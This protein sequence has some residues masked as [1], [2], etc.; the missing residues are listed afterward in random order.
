MRLELLSLF[1]AGT[2]FGCTHYAS[3]HAFKRGPNY[4]APR[5]M[6]IVVAR[7][8][9]VRAVDDAGFVEAT[10]RAASEELR[11]RGVEGRV[12]DA[13]APPGPRA[14]LTF[15]VWKP[16]QG[17]LPAMTEAMRDES[18]I[19]VLVSVV[20]EDGNA[21][22]AG[23]VDGVELTRGANT[24]DAA[25]ATGRSIARALADDAY[26]PKSSTSLETTLP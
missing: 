25:E 24:H 21:V 1:T 16:G 11:S 3:W 5:S 8:D 26:V 12:F 10:V 4:R 15:V 13:V 14:D 2:L 22:L 23:R 7:S 19:E 18:F 6:S 20:N 17:P 9:A